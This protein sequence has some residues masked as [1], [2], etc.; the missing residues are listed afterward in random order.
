MTVHVLMNWA[1]ICWK[2]LCNF[3]TFY[4]KF[5]WNVS[6]LSFCW[7]SLFATTWTSALSDIFWKPSVV[8]LFELSLRT[9]EI[10]LTNFKGFLIKL[11]L[12]VELGEVVGELGWEWYSGFV[13]RSIKKFLPKMLGTL[14]LSLARIFLYLWC[15]R[16]MFSVSTSNELDRTGFKISCSS[17][18]RT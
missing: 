9:V 8:F 11:F 3:L 17:E 6:L 12:L 15:D 4:I 7:F 14:P 16:I 5:S 18:I 2:W 10:F 13:F 1:R